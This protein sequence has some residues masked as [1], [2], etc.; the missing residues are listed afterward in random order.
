[1]ECGAC[2]TWITDADRYTDLEEPLF[3]EPPMILNNNVPNDHNSDTGSSILTNITQLLSI[4]WI[5]PIWNRCNVTALF[6]ASVHIPSTIVTVQEVFSG[7]IVT[8]TT[9]DDETSSNMNPSDCDNVT[10]VTEASS[11]SKYFESYSIE[12][13]PS[14]DWV[15][16]VQQSW[17]PIIVANKF[18]LHFPWHTN[19]TIQYAIQEYKQQQLHNSSDTL[20]NTINKDDDQF[21]R[22]LLQGGIAFGTGEHATTQLCLEWLYSTVMT[23]LLQQPQQQQNETISILDYGTGSGVLG[24]AGCAIGRQYQQQQQ[25]SND[26]DDEYDINPV[27][28]IG[29][30]IDIDACRIAN[31][32]AML[33]GNLPMRSY[34]P[35]LQFNI[36]NNNNNNDN[37]NT[38]TMDSESQS[39]LYK[40]H[41]KNNHQQQTTTSTDENDVDDMV[42]HLSNMEPFDICVANILAGPLIVLAPIL[43]QYMK[44]G[45]MI[46]M[47]GILFHQSTS[48][49][50]AYESVGF[51]N[52]H[53][54]Q[55]LRGWVLISAQKP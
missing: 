8:E 35:S 42:I 11:T 28:A 26:S 51:S 53:V 39:L 49:I 45:A 13:V 12:T 16:T 4:P 9:Q 2:A 21:I 17:N 47:S 36:N 52:V 50:Q 37:Y 43:F 22:I 27:S 14:K 29:I 33:N 23:S 54:Y 19:D 1:M 3:N 20:T 18:L 44:H 6:P 15:T 32:N 30:D 41:Y 34:I 5:A 7:I 10:I 31:L 55:E 38:F 48:V 24:I 46:G 40:A 25:Q